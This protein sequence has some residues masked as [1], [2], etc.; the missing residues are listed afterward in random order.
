M[1]IHVLDQHPVRLVV[2]SDALQLGF[3]LVQ[4]LLGEPDDGRVVMMMKR[5]MK[6]MLEIMLE[7]M[8]R[9]LMVQCS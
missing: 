1:V 9:V 5:V 6:I 4:Q 3:M 8:E 7:V 2:A